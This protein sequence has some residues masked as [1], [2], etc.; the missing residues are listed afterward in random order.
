MELCA[1]TSKARTYL[2]TLTSVGSFLWRLSM[3][4]KQ[5]SNQNVSRQPGNSPLRHRSSGVVRPDSGRPAIQKD[6]RQQ[7]DQYWDDL[8]R[9]SLVWSHCD[10]HYDHM[11]T[12]TSVRTCFSWPTWMDGAGRC[13][14]E[15]FVGTGSG[16]VAGSHPGS[17]WQQRKTRRKL[18]RYRA[19]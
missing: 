3:Y 5:S 14:N 6:H 11:I 12:M 19:R 9:R 7:H 15:R 4:R 2:S 17:C 18:S 8:R 16:L 1:K 10:S 13:T